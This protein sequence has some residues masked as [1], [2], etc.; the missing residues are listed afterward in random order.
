MVSWARTVDPVA[1][2]VSLTEVKNWVKLLN[3]D[4]ATDL[5]LGGL[6]SAA[7]QY[8]EDVCAIAFLP[9]TWELKLDSFGGRDILLPRYPVR[10]ITSITYFDSDNASQTYA[11]A[12]YALGAR[13]DGLNFVQLVDGST[14]PSVYNRT[15][16]ITITFSAG[17]DSA[18][19]CPALL[20]VLLQLLVSHWFE[21][22]EIVTAGSVG[23]IP[24]TY[25]AVAANYIRELVYD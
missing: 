3:T 2:P 10:S 24:M 7:R 11:G 19:E 20:K 4:A 1:E 13:E 9:Q 14:W 21:N 8:T 15:G 6:I 23:S 18:Q 17:Y 12:N 25:D 5:M 22:R 16:A